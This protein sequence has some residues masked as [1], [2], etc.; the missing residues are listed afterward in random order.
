[1]CVFSGSVLVCVFVFVCLCVCVC[2]LALCLCLPPH[3][4]FATQYDV[5]LFQRIGMCICVYAD[6]VLVCVYVCVCMCA[7][8][9]LVFASACFLHH[10]V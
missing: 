9:V 2:V 6:T 5:E 3:V 7:G 10:T 1:M 8:T 4:S